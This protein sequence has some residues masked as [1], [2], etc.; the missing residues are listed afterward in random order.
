MASDTFEGAWRKVLTYV[1]NCPPL[2]AQDW[3]RTAYRQVAVRRSWGFLRAES[4]LTTQ[5]ARS[6]AVGVTFGDATVTSAALFVAG[7]V[8]RQFRV[9]TYPV[10]TIQTFTSTSSVELDQ[11]FGGTT[12]AAATGQ[13][14]DAYTTL[15]A[16]FGRFYLVADPYN[17][18]RMVH[19]LTAEQ[20]HRLDPTRTSSDSGPRALATRRLS[21]V[22]A[23]VGQVQYEYWPYPTAARSYPYY[24]FRRPDDLTDDSA[25][26]GVLATR[27]DILIHGALRE[28]ARWPGT[29][30]HPNPYFNLATYRTYQQEFED[31][32]QKLTLKDDDQYLDN[33]VTVD[34]GRWP[35]ADLLYGTSSLRASD[36]T[37]GDYYAGSYPGLY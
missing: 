2:L 20:L 4:A 24:Y 32:V 12:N 10:Y 29:A 31:E 23:T 25:F 19:W 21:T 7:D 6:I 13:I 17:Q 3:V 34:Y 14:L 5:A 36:A 8:G 9:G 33:L 22:P 37:V 30:D 27:S 28:A 18:R 1:P 16:D 35:M 26:L 15:P 11:P